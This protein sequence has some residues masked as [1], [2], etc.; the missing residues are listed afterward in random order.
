MNRIVTFNHRK[1]LYQLTL[2]QIYIASLVGYQLKLKLK[3]YGLN[4]FEAS[5]WLTADYNFRASKHPFYSV[6]TSHG[7]LVPFSCLLFPLTKTLLQA[8]IVNTKYKNL[9]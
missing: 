9:R 1:I 4:F 7:W 2:M 5:N 6:E 8:N 3:R